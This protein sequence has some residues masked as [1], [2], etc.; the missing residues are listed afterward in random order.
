MT[1]YN[2][3]MQTRGNTFKARKL[4]IEILNNNITTP[5]NLTGCAILI[6]FKLTTR[7]NAFLEWNTADNS[8]LITDAVNGEFEMQQTLLDVTPSIY[9]Y[10]VQVTFPDGTVKTYFKGNFKIEADVSRNS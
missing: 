4:V 1:V 3:P 6:Q 2:F 9:M 10:D 7:F 5:L 8:I